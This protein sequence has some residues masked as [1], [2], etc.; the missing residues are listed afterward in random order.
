MVISHDSDF[1][2]IYATMIGKVKIKKDSKESYTA[3]TD[4]GI[5][6]LYKTK[7]NTYKVKY[8]LLGLL[9]ISN[10]KL[11]KIEL[12]TEDVEG[13]YMIVANMM[14][15]FTHIAGEKV[16]KPTYIPEVWKSYLGHY[17]VLNNFQ[18]K[19]WKIV[20]VEFKIEDGYPEVKTKYKSGETATTLL[21]P[22]NDTEA[23]IEGLGRSMQETIYVKD[24]IFHAQ[25][26]RFKKIE[27]KKND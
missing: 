10:D 11:D 1:E 12:Y 6:K 7:N 13:H 3:Y 14:G 25:G 17:K 21:K 26:L 16:K 22:I 15:V 8:K 24:G 23:I 4:S 18:P 9:A 2:G 5:F 20:D 19:E 27:E